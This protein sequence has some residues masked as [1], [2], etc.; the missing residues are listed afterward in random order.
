MSAKLRQIRAYVMHGRLRERIGGRLSDHLLDYSEFFQRLAELPSA[1]TEVTIAPGLAIAVATTSHERDFVHFRFISGNPEDFPLIFNRETGRTLET[2][3]PE[4]SWLAFPTR[5]SVV[6]DN[7]LILIEYRRRGVS[8]TNLERYFESISDV[9]GYPG[10]VQLDLDPLPAPSLERE[11]LELAR[12]R[13]ASLIVNRPNTDWNDAS[14]ALSDLAGSSGGK[15]AEV[16]VHAPRGESL[17]REEGIVPLILTHIRRGLSNVKNLRVVGRRRGEEV[18]RTVSLAKHQMRTTAAVD[19]N[20][21]L[22][23]QETEVHAAMRDLAEQAAP[24]THS[25]TDVPSAVEDS[26]HQV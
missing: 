24:I 10:H 18:D 20:A 7:R 3:P 12:I 2:R 26:G 6:P 4:N 21:P 1:Q 14:D 22:L 5:V 19:D 15:D 11:I 23:E 25:R 8:A 16:V 13:E 9:M 17:N